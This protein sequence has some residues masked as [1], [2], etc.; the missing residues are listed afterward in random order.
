MNQR[1]AL[2]VGLTALCCAFALRA[3]ELELPKRLLT[4]LTKPNIAPFLI[5]LET[6]RDVRFSLSVGTFSPDF[7]ESSPAAANAD[8][9]ALESA[10]IEITNTTAEAPD[11]AALLAQP[12]SWQLRGTEP[13]VLILHTHATESYTQGDEPYAE[14]SDWRT[15]D[16]DYNL[17]S[18]GARVRERLEAAGIPTLQDRALHDYPSYNGSYVDARGSIAEYLEAY[19]SIALVLDLHR[20]AA[21]SGNGQLRTVALDGEEEIAQLMVVIGANHGEYQQNLALG[22]KLT[23]VLEERTPGITRPLQLRPLRFNQDLSSGALLI[24]VGA[25]GNSHAEALRA[26]DKLADAIIALASGTA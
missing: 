17:L 19:P 6:G 14:V 21:D 18:L 2:R 5:Y 22:L 11:L 23:A 9:L 26:A 8:P 12:L 1:Q 24:E 13:T 10:E 20:D 3:G 25:A 7:G 15:L 16:E 4:W